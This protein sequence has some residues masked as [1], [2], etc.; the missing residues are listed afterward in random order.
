MCRCEDRL[1]VRSFNL[2]LLSALEQLIVGGFSPD[3]CPMQ[4]I[5]RSGLH[6]W[7]LRIGAKVSQYSAVHQSIL[8]AAAKCSLDAALSPA[9]AG[10]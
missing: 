2:T 8:N 3:S 7:G 5:S 10:D 9:Y 4:Q 1:V 6:N